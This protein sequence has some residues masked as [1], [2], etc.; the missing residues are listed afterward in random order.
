MK[1]YIKCLICVMI[2]FSL[3]LC[4]ACGSGSKKI[5]AE[6]LIGNWRYEDDEVVASFTFY[7]D[8][9]GD[10]SSESKVKV[11]SYASSFSYTIDGD[12]L[13]IVDGYKKTDYKIKLSDNMLTMTDKDGNS[14]DYVPYEKEK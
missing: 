10:I 4:A 6:D 12:A 11:G 2:A 14:R 5:T 13:H 8:G 3:L 9:S 1:R 7:K